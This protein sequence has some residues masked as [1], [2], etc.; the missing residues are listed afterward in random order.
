MLENI[1]NVLR[2]NGFE[3]ALSVISFAIG[4]FF[5]QVQGWRQYARR[6]F[7]DRLNVSLNFVA[8]GRFAIRTLLERSGSEVFRNAHMLRRVMRAAERTDVDALLD[9]PDDEYWYYLNA[10]LNAISEQFAE[11]YV[12]Q[13]AGLSDQVQTYL[14]FLTS[15]N[16]PSVRQRKVRAMLIRESLLLDVADGPPPTFRNPFHEARWNT[17]KMAAVEWRRSE[18]ATPRMREVSICV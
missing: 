2:D 14:L 17:L 13:E 5:G 1:L 10:V 18:G 16:D 8:D 11:G 6:T 4:G 15:E 3:I 9:L 12:R 7:Y